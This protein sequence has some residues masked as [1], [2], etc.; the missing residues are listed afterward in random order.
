MRATIIA[1]V[2]TAGPAPLACKVASYERRVSATHMYLSS[3]SYSLTC[4]PAGAPYNRDCHHKQYTWYGNGASSKI[5][6]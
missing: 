5:R 1:P 3:R 6:I 2:P 4:N